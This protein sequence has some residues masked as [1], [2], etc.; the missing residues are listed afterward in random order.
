LFEDGE[1][2]IGT[3]SRASLAAIIIELRDR[4]GTSTIPTIRALRTWA[5][6]VPVLGYCGLSKTAGNDIVMAV[7]A[8]VSGLIFPG[9]DNLPEALQTILAS[10]VD[11]CAAMYVLRE[12]EHLVPRAVLPIIEHCLVN[13]RNSVTV[14]DVAAAL[15]IQRR[16]L[17]NRL[18][19]AGMPVPSALI[20]WSCLLV[21]ARLLEDPRR[22]VEQIAFGLG[23]E[24]GSALCHMVKRYTGLR[25]SE[26]RENGG[27]SCVVHSFER[28]VAEQRAHRRNEVFG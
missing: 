4:S 9:S 2:L 8:G 18:A 23:Y 17:V 12:I 10:A 6:A 5:P 16:T 21:A 25:A 26:V 27:L 22:S 28:A 3:V 19:A 20:S 24:S 14:E 11:D 1:R 7:R 13:A 15:R